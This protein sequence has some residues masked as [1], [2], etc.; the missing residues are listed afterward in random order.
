MYPIFFKF[1]VGLNLSY[2]SLSTHVRFIFNTRY[3]FFLNFQPT[4]DLTSAFS[5]SFFLFSAPLYPQKRPPDN[6]TI[7]SKKPICNKHERIFSHDPY[8][9]FNLF[10]KRLTR[11]SS[12]SVCSAKVHA[13]IV[14]GSTL[15]RMRESCVAGVC[16]TV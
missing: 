3:N 5:F 2:T 13:K 12:D 16:L 14:L 15:L 8:F 4:Y 11:I 9:Y 7:T 1:Y 6:P 10:T